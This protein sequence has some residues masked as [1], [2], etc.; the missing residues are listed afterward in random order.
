MQKNMNASQI[1]MNY[2]EVD[3]HPP[4]PTDPMI[5]GIMIASMEIYYSTSR[6]PS[7]AAPVHAV[8]HLR[9]S[10]ANV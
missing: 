1:D 5:A 10:P 3:V 2:A 8:R 4:L 7:Q 9:S 6:T